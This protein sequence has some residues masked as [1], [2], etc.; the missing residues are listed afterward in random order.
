M[1]PQLLLQHQRSGTVVDAL[2]FYLQRLYTVLGQ[3]YSSD[4]LFTPKVPIFTTLSHCAM[5]MR[6]GENFSLH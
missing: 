4:A 6:T 5:Y 3:K 1:D 2:D